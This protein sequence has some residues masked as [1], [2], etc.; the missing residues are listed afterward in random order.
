MIIVQKYVYFLYTSDNYT[1]KEN[2]AHVCTCV[3]FGGGNL[4]HSRLQTYEIWSKPNLS[5][6]R[7]LQSK[8]ENTGEGN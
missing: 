8:I 2:L 5:R 7:S 4:T 6:E 3:C 1:K